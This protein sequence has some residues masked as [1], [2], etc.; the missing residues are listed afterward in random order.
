MTRDG[1]WRRRRL[2]DARLYLCCDRT[3]GGGDLA[4]FLDAVLSAG[5]DI[6]QLRDK[7]ALEDDLFEAGPVFRAAALRHGALFVLNDEPLFAADLDADGVHLGQ[8]DAPVREGRR[9][10]GADR[11]VGLSTHAAEEVDAA[12]GSDCDYFAVGPVWA[13]P[14]KEGRAGIGL[15][16]V[17]HAAAVAER[18]RQSAVA[19]RLRQSAAADRPWFVTGDMRVETIP[20]VRAAGA[21]RF[22]VVRAITGADDPADAVRAIRAALR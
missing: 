9:A 3:A 2:A 16:P 8:D 13:T 17:R 12:V 19:D 15:E 6:V 10:V 1:Q 11:L 21:E 22:V 18:L 7:H 14:T 5:V 4:G 20:E